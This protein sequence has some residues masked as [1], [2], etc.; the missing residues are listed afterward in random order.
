MVVHTNNHTFLDVACAVMDG[1]SPH[2]IIGSEEIY[3]TLRSVHPTTLKT[4]RLCKC[5]SNSAVV[6]CYDRTNHL[7]DRLKIYMEDGLSDILVLCESDKMK[8]ITL[9]A[10]QHRRRSINCLEV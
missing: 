1:P 8:E 2:I 7:D 3:N 5:N 10:H 4:Y 6:D 9:M